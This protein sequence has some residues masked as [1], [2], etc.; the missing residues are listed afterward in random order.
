[1]EILASKSTG[2]AVGAALILMQAVT[3]AADGRAT[4][5]DA[6]RARAT[7]IEAGYSEAAVAS[8]GDERNVTMCLRPQQLEDVNEVSVSISAAMRNVDPH[9]ELHGVE[10]IRPMVGSYP[11]CRSELEIVFLFVLG[12]HGRR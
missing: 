11:G 8:V 12:S 7:L 4:A 6:E 1:M 5:A 2:A 9:M 3:F 10:V